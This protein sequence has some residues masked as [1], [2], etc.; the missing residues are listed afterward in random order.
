[1]SKQLFIIHLANETPNQFINLLSE[2]IQNWREV[3]NLLSQSLEHVH[4]FV[5][6]VLIPNDDNGKLSKV[7]VPSHYILAI[8][9]IGEDKLPLGFREGNQ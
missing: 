3:N 7:Y 2:Y 6:L 1:M 8:S 5:E 9:D 4:P